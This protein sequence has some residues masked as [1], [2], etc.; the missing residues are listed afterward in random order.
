MT[1]VLC[2]FDL[3]KL[4]SLTFVYYIFFPGVFCRST[5]DSFLHKKV[6]D[7]LKKYL[8]NNYVFYTQRQTT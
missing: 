2:L 7:R 1:V 6:I 3:V 5:F 4:Y 8:L